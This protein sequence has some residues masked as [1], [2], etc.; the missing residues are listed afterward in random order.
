M[1][2]QYLGPDG[3]VVQNYILRVADNAF[4]PFDLDNSDYIAYLAWVEA[5]GVPTPADEA[6]E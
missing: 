3:Q 2:K 5:G 1:Y 4:I 6:A